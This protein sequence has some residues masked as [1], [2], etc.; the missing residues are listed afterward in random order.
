MNLLGTL[1]IM[2]TQ[3][4]QYLN[5]INR[6]F[7]ATTAE[8]F[9]QTRGRAW[10]GWVRLAEYIDAPLSVLDVGCGNGRFGIFLAQALD[11][12]IQYHGVDNNDQLLNYANSAL[13]PF[14]NVQTKL[15]TLD[16][17]AD[18]LPPAEYDLVVLFGVIHHVPG[19]QNRQQFIAELAK[20]V[21]PGGML[22]FAAWRFYEYA[23]FRERLV[24]WSVD[25][26]PDGMKDT[27][28]EEH[29]YLLDWRRGERA[30]RYCH[31][32]DDAELDTLIQA[33]NMREVTRYR[34]DGSDNAMNA[35]VILKKYLS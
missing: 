31:Y 7:Y 11:G 28:L 32:V 9:D 18:S 19:A 27:Q 35:Y 16:V 12:R 29:D 33:S 26:L 5:D 20:R 6:E 13:A 2:K 25:T 1:T 22:A 30:L 21:K 14:A 17:I 23:R 24:E 3:T 4:I 8:D 10:A 34:A 15:D